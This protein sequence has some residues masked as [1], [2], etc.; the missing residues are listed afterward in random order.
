MAEKNKQADKEIKKEEIEDK[1]AKRKENEEKEAKKIFYG[2]NFLYEFIYNHKKELGLPERFKIGGGKRYKDRLYQIN[3]GGYNPFRTTY[4]TP[5]K[6]PKIKLSILD[7]KKLIKTINGK[8]A[9]IYNLMEKE[10]FPKNYKYNED[11]KIKIK[12]KKDFDELLKTPKEL[13]K[14]V[15]RDVKYN[16]N[17][18]TKDIR[19]FKEELNEIE[20]LRKKG[21]EERKELN[22]LKKKKDKTEEELFRIQLLENSQTEIKSLKGLRKKIKK[23]LEEKETYKKGLEEKYNEYLQKKDKIKA[24]KKKYEEKLNMEIKMM[25]NE[26]NEKLKNI[27][28]QNAEEIKKIQENAD[29]SAKE[30]EAKIKDLEKTHQAAVEQLEK[31]KE[32]LEEDYNEKINELEANKRNIEFLEKKNEEIDKENKNKEEV[33]KAKDEE[34]DT[35]R[36]MLAHANAKR[37]EAEV[38]KKQLKEELKAQNEQPKSTYKPSNTPPTLKDYIKDK[39]INKSYSLEK[40]ELIKVIEKD[41]NEHKLPKDID[42]TKLADTIYFQGAKYISKHMKKI[43]SL[44]KLTGYDNDLYNKLPPELAGEIQKYIHDKALED[45]RKKNIRYILPKE[46]PRWKKAVNKGINPMLGRGAWSK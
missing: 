15:S 39:V 18:I 41:I 37:H 29:I 33:I 43:K 46:M 12:D 42:V 35:K 4:L 28:K 20:E 6:E 19:K 44:A 16:L 10:G 1:E 21:D 27:Q 14:I 26:Y 40:D 38:E 36:N 8:E 3:E 25:E 17:K 5:N 30:K 22:K 9:E 31:D 34:I 2:P 11:L 7:V 23:G 32:K 45:I 13:I 24:V